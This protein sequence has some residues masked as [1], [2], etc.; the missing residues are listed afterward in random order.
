MRSR[1]WRSIFAQWRAVVVFVCLGDLVRASGG[2]VAGSYAARLGRLNKLIVD[3]EWTAYRTTEGAD[4]FDMNAWRRQDNIPVEYC[5][6]FVLRPHARLHQRAD[7]RDARSVDKSWLDGIHVSRAEADDG[8][9]HASRDR[10][11]WQFTG[12]IPIIT[13]LELWQT[14]DIR[15]GILELLEQGKLTIESEQPDRVVL[16]TRALYDP[17]E[18]WQVAV[19]LDPFRSWTPMK[20]R[21]VLA[22]GKGVIAEEMRVVDTMVVNG[23][24]LISDAVI[25]VDNTRVA[26]GRP[27]VYHYVVKRATQ[28]ES[29][30]KAALAVEIPKSNVRIIDEIGQYWKHVDAHGRVLEEKHWTAEQRAEDLKGVS[31]SIAK[32]EEAQAAKA[33]RARVLPFIVAGSALV[34][35]ALYTVYRLR[36]SGMARG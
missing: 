22:V 33:T 25:V 27:Q 10:S 35:L 4:P 26:P 12:P 28:D 8:S 11:R 24:H 6:A 1:P 15:V 30:T 32:A 2:D 17:P 31:E 9:W 3:F 13:P 16:G 20:V 18:N 7:F 29:M 21:A 23:C 34:T 19:E 36:R 5:R 14:L